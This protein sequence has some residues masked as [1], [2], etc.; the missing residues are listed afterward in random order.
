M[1]IHFHDS[2]YHDTPEQINYSIVHLP[3]IISGR[4]YGYNPTIMIHLSLN[5]FYQIPNSLRSNSLLV[6]VNKG[7]G[8]GN[9]N[10]AFCLRSLVNRH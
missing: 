8:N 9:D 4:I 10:P 7:M 2:L 5:L 3:G 1:D 6:S